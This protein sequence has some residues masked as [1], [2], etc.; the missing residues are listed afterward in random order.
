MET[1]NEGRR[2]NWGFFG[3]IRSLCQKGDFG[4]AYSLF[5]SSSSFDRPDSSIR[6]GDVRNYIRSQPG[7]CEELCIESM[8]DRGPLM[9]QDSSNHWSALHI[10]KDDWK[11]FIGTKVI[12]DQDSFNLDIAIRE[13]ILTLGEHFIWAIEKLLNCLYEIQNPGPIDE[14][15]RADYINHLMYM[16]RHGLHEEA[17]WLKGLDN[18]EPYRYD[19]SLH[20]ALSSGISYRTVKS[21][22]QMWLYIV[23]TII[24]TEEPKF[25]S[26]RRRRDPSPIWDFECD[27]PVEDLYPD[28]VLPDL[29]FNRFLL[30]KMMDKG[31]L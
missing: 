24:M 28:G 10:Q 31:L 13:Y 7:F 4:S 14:I 12:A 2:N 27:E 29:A 3:E 15:D 23:Y 21:M 5:A 16:Y 18:Y 26:P 9:F 6:K 22:D 1:V 19:G 30:K 20:V 11:M 8:C 17:K 25:G